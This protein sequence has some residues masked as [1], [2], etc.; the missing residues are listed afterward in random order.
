MIRNRARPR[1]KTTNWTDQYSL[2]LVKKIPNFTIDYSDES[3]LYKSVTLKRLQ[4]QGYL[5]IVNTRERTHTLMLTEK[6]AQ[7]YQQMRTQGRGYVDEIIKNP[8]YSLTSLGRVPVRYDDFWEWLYHSTPEHYPTVKALAAQ[9]DVSSITFLTILTEL[10]DL[11]VESELLRFYSENKD[12]CAELFQTIQA[13]EADYISL[14]H[15][16]FLDLEHENGNKVPELS[17]EFV[18]ARYVL[19]VGREAES[20]WKNYCKWHPHANPLSSGWVT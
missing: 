4:E 10:N 7:A 6:G 20:I 18:K 8:I 5:K 11:G 2:H 14:L 3:E 12:L 15:D 1:T 17:E 9:L 16:F 19:Q 13:K